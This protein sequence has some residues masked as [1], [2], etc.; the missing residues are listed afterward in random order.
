V[1]GGEAVAGAVDVAVRLH[2][3]EKLPESDAV[4]LADG[5]EPADGATVKLSG[6]VA[7]A[8]VRGVAD[9]LRLTVALELTRGDTEVDPDADSPGDAET[10]A[11]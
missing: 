3:G 5:V 11:V 7:L 9:T 6:A 4:E 8:L 10:D 1:T 2:V